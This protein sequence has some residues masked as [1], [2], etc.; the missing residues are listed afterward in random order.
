MQHTQPNRWWKDRV[1]TLGLCAAMVVM[2]LGLL[3]HAPAAARSLLD[4]LQFDRA[5]ILHGQIWRLLTG[6]LVHW[7]LEH[8]L[9][10]VGVFLA[11]GLMY[12]P[13]RRRQYP[14]LLLAAALSVGLSVLSFLPEMSIYRGLSGVD[15]GQ[16][17]LALAVEFQLARTERRRWLW[18]APVLGIFTLK[19][20]SETVSGQMFFGTESLGNIGLP[21]PLAHAAGA[22]AVLALCISRKA[23]RWSGAVMKPSYSSAS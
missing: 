10:D 2:N 14:W 11:I 12:E 19:I 17:V 7:S 23:F 18:L 8:F 16:F 15:S 21:T 20:V 22:T 1:W 9:L 3:P 4:Y 6:N 5:A 13:A